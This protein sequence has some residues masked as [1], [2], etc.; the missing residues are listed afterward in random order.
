[1]QNSWLPYSGLKM[2]AVM[3]AIAAAA[4]M[5]GCSDSKNEAPAPATATPPAATPAAA[6]P[7]TKRVIDQLFDTETIGMNLAYVEKIAGPAMRSEFH[8]HQFR[9]DG[10]DIT[11]VS[12]EAD[13]VIESV[14]IDIAPSCNLSL[15]SVLNVSEGQPDIKLGDSV[16]MPQKEYRIKI[17]GTVIAAQELRQQLPRAGR[18][19]QGS[20][21]IWH[22][23][24]KLQAQ[25]LR[26]L[27]G[28]Q[29]GLSVET[30]EHQL[31]HAAL[32]PL[33]LQL[34]EHLR[35]GNNAAK[36]LITDRPGLTTFPNHRHQKFSLSHPPQVN[37]LR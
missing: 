26:H 7:E 21:T 13:K 12:D 31:E 5:A 2:G 16:A 17:H 34:P 3:A 35:G 33:G 18:R 23:M 25:P 15:K 24:Q 10:C 36:G 1:M 9:T 6:A 11:L 14:E 20:A 28:R 30:V 37:D 27:L 32:Y 8:R 22:D 19:Q 4:L 29:T